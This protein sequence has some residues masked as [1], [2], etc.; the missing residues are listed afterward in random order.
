MKIRKIVQVLFLIGLLMGLI[1]CSKKP[2][3][4][5]AVQAYLTAWEN[6]Q[7]EEMYEQL[8]E[9]SKET[10]DK[11]TFVE[12]YEN[13]YAG[14]QANNLKLEPNFPEDGIKVSENEETKV[15]YLLE[16]QTIGGE[17]SFLHDVSLVK[18]S[19]DKGDKW[20]INWDASMIF[21]Q[22]EEN[23]KIRVNTLHAKRGEIF[24]RNGK[25]LAING[26]ALNIGIVPERLPE[27]ESATFKKLAS[28]I[29]VSVKDI[30][31]KMS[32]SWVQPDT[33][34]PVTMIAKSD[35]RLD[36][37]LDI[38]GVTYVEADARVYPYKDVTAHLTGY[39]QEIN[40]EE[41]EELKS[42]GYQEGDQ[43]GKSGLEKI[44][45]DKLR[46]KDGGRIF[47]TDEEG[48]EKQELAQQDPI[49][50]EEIALTIDIE[51]QKNAYGQLKGEVGT[52]T[53]I[54]GNT[55]EVLA[56]VNSPAYDPNQFVLGLSSKDWDTLN[57]DPNKP[58]LNRFANTSAPG[59][60]IK[61]ITAAIAL[62]GEAIKPDSTF[63]IKGLKWQQ[64]DS[65]GKYF[66]SRVSDP[67]KPID[68]NTA[69][70]YSD[71]I[72][73]AQAALKTGEDKFVEYA[74]DFGFHESL[75]FDFPIKQSKIAENNKFDSEI[76]L[77]DSGYGQ[78]KV[79]MNILHTALAYTAFIHEGNILQPSL[80]KNEAN[81][82]NL[83]WKEAVIS[84]ETAAFINDALIQVVEH[85]NGTGKA[86][87]IAS[88]KIAGKTGTTELKKSQSEKGQENGFF[89]AYDSQN[90]E[91]LVAMQ[92]ENVESRGGSS[93]VV[94][95]VKNILQSSPSH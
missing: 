49:H 32:A 8:S 94:P 52:A 13:I 34:V 31:K 76:Q 62:K 88:K 84:K 78:G 45:E 21:P 67:G 23:D 24:D 63:D 60:V 75:P 25:E 39:V 64:N 16:M 33:F 46:G 14:I 81:E 79:E 20:S 10:I 71:N 74:K 86:A 36:D 19:N 12:R 68:L 55:A 80:L 48:I 57:D 7:F 58:M 43:I 54:N 4:E 18:E 72:Y 44:F 6:E 61:P 28:L 47:I 37:L 41:L 42:E 87:K 69:L 9:Q 92:V 27:D 3:P 59:S 56:L 65:W 77:A 95:K 66:I 15:E 2:T 38:D 11:K 51:V 82:D 89:V 1:A 22:M 35:S 93:F 73:F 53:A 5:D 40:A 26:K 29:D 85:P 91:L 70:I 83:Y 17:I 90:P 50:G 30:E